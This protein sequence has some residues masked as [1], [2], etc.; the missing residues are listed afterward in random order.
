MKDIEIL[1]YNYL[2]MARSLGSSGTGTL[3][4]GLS[5]DVLER[6]AQM[7]ID[8]IRKLAASIG[9]S[10]VSFRFNEKQMKMM[11][12]MP[13]SYRSHYAVSICPKEH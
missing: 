10:V 13:K 2:L 12:D 9:L 3:I 8:E 6:L 11:M 1:N 5:K 7:D 4:T